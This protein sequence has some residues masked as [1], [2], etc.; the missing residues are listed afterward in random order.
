MGYDKKK[1]AALLR[2]IYDH[3]T[4]N[5]AGIQDYDR[6]MVVGGRGSSFSFASEKGVTL[7][8]TISDS[9]GPHRR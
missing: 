5:A 3:T 7:Q 2:A 1:L 9:A 4:T 8:G 6:V